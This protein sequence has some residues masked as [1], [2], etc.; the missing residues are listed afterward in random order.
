MSPAPSYLLTDVNFARIGFSDSGRAVTIDF[1]NMQDGSPCAQLIAEGVVAFNYHNT[2]TDDEEALPAYVGE[3]TWREWQ[4]EEASSVL[5]G[6]GYG[7]VTQGGQTF[8]PESRYFHISA[9]G[10]ELAVDLICSK[11]R[12]SR[13]QA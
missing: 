1:L 13:Q 8:A 7:F 6:I 3:V 11:Y 12:L 5:L 9:Q 2:F 4:R 10:G